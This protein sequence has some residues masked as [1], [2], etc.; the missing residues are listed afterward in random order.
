MQVEVSES[1]KNELRSAYEGE[2][3]G[4]LLYHQSAISVGDCDAGKAFAGIAGVER[5]TY[6]AMTP[7]ARRHGIEPRQ[8]HVQAVVQ[9]RFSELSQTAW[10]DFLQKAC[11]DWPGIVIRFQELQRAAPENDRVALERL[12]AHEVALVSFVNGLLNGTPIDRALRMLIDY[13]VATSHI[14]GFSL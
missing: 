13:R 4:S 11:A 10:P 5:I 8:D 1:Y 2:L 9:R 6:E 14:M 12:V 3:I 7:A